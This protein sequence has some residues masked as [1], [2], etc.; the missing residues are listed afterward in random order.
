MEEQVDLPIDGVL[1]SLMVVMAA[2]RRGG[3]AVAE[4]G[5]FAAEIRVLCGGV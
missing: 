3:D 5:V 1:G 2:T 4:I